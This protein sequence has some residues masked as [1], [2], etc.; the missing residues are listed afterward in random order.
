MAVY[1][2]VQWSAG[3]EVTSEKL[4]AMA[5]NEQYLKDNAIVGQIQYLAGAHGE[6]PFSRPTGQTIT[7]T[8]MCGLYVPF[9][10]E[11]VSVAY[12][13]VFVNYPTN[14]FSFPPIITATLAQGQ[15]VPM[16]IVCFQDFSTSTAGF[17]IYAPNGTAMPI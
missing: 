9:S 10:S 12:W 14:F 7:A 4:N 16:T 15:R 17:E 3:D 2:T 11:G 5:Q 1:T 8:K 13:E 6:V